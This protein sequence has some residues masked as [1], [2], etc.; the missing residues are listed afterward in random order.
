[1]ESARLSKLSTTLLLPGVIKAVLLGTGQ[2]MVPQSARAP[3]TALLC[4]GE[5]LAADLRELACRIRLT[6]TR[7]T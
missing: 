2:E 3:I 6:V 7:P 4:A 1:V 5:H